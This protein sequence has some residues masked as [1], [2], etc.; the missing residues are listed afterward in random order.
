MKKI[1]NTPELK[2]EMLI[3]QDVMAASEEIE[4]SDT[5][6]SDTDQVDNTFV[7]ASMFAYG[8]LD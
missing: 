1:Y 8:N 5:D 2:D 3:A 4:A 6:I 7:E